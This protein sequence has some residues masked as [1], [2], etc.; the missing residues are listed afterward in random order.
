MFSNVPYI[1]VA[2]LNFSYY[3][4]E[5]KSDPVGTEVPVV[6]TFVLWNYNLT[7]LVCGTTTVP[8]KWSKLLP[9]ATAHLTFTVAKKD[10]ASI[11]DVHPN[12]T[13][14]VVPMIPQTNFPPSIF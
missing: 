13:S 6:A 2:Y 12:Y 8:S 9:V 4:S 7:I 3:G 5:L 14:Y 1:Q 11:H 10:I